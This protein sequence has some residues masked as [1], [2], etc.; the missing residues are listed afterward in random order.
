MALTK[1]ERE[2]I[3]EEEMLRN[4]IRGE[5]DL[6]SNAEDIYAEYMIFGPSLVFIVG[7]IYL[8]FFY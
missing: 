6:K 5:K 8:I 3:I 2:K 7:I 1:E 4:E